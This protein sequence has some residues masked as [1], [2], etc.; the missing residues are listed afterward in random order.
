MKIKLL[1]LTAVLVLAANH[2]FGQCT[3][4]SY[5]N[6]GIYPDSATGLDPAYAGT[7]YNMVVNIKIPTDTVAVVGGNSWP[8]HVDSVRVLSVSGLPF[9]FS[10]ACNTPASTWPGGANGCI[11]I[12]GSP[13]LSLMGTYPLKVYTRAYVY[14]STL[15]SQ[16]QDDSVTYYKIVINWPQGIAN[17]DGAK[18]SVLQ[19]TPNPFSGNTEVFYTVP[20]TGKAEFKVFNLLGKAVYGKSVIAEAGVNKLVF[21]SKDLAPG[22]YMY[23]IN[24]GN[25]AIT[26][27]MIVSPNR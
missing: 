19:N 25:S 15:G 18:F 12:Q 14:N 6:P 5:P 2:S 22:I 27:R 20:A 21:N 24:N 9:S 7:S 4:G 23:S 26:R 8:I 1:Y 17:N 13:T 3:P 16:Q 10:Y 11:L